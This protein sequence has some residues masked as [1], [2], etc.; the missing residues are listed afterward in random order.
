MQHICRCLLFILVQFT[1]LV[2]C[3][4]MRARASRYFYLFIAEITVVFQCVLLCLFFY[5]FFVEI[6]TRTS[7]IVVFFGY[8]FIL[9][10]IGNFIFPVEYNQFICCFCTV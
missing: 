7:D 2:F 3:L 6:Y 9:L 4:F 10:R 8:S 5:C 1:A